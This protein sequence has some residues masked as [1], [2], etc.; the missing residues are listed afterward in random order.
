ME[1][2]FK[3]NIL[4]FVGGGPDPLYP[5][6]K[7][8]MWDDFKLRVFPFFFPFFFFFLFSSLFFSSRRHLHP[9]RAKCFAELEFRS[10]VLNVRLR[11]DK[12]AVVVLKM[13]YVYNFAD[14]S[15]LSKHDTNTNPTGLC[16]LSAD[17]NNTVLAC[18]GVKPGHVRIDLFDINKSHV[19]AAHTGEL[20]QLVLNAEGTLLAT[21]SEKGTLIRVWDT[22]TGVKVREFRR[23]TVSATIYS[24][25]FSRNSKYL[26]VGSDKGTVHVYA[27]Y[28]T[29]GKI[30]GAS[31][32]NSKMADDAEIDAGDT[33]AAATSAPPPPPP[34]VAPAPAP[35]SEDLSDARIDDTAS[36]SVQNKQSKLSF[37]KDILPGYF[38]SEWSFASFT[39]D[40]ADPTKKFFCSF[41]S[42]ETT[43]LVLCEDG[44]YFKYLLKPE[45]ARIVQIGHASFR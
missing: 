34:A 28:D 39:V 3:C 38:S 42:D 13:V 18:P 41:G 2:L 17:H 37:M 14:L 19:I 45:Q 44:T 20:T 7:V 36:S 31:A 5:R 22:T 6:N 4:A 15:L 43:I 33:T 23:G 24:V 10:E 27:L 12:I 40:V 25:A 30:G 8:M 35:T 29:A 1:M 21:A 26:V 32:T 9:K 16:A 11:R